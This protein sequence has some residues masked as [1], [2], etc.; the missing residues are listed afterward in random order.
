[1]HGNEN[2]DAENYL[3]N[4]QGI[5]ELR[6]HGESWPI[7]EHRAHVG[8]GRASRIYWA[9]ILQSWDFSMTFS[10]EDDTQT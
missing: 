6:L 10:E 4:I 7:L 1:M 3:K 5:R 8:S 9:N 2:I